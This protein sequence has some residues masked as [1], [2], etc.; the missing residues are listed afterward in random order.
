MTNRLFEI[1]LELQ[2]IA[3]REAMSLWRL[4]RKAEKR[5]CSQEL[6]RAI[7]DEAWDLYNSY[8]ANPGWLLDWKTEY[9]FKYAFC[10]ERRR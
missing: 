9:Y 1:E 7:R 4:A 3:D 10:G 6:V 5:R 2:K 8:K